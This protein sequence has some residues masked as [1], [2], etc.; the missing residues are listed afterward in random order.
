[1]QPAIGFERAE[2]E[3]LHSAMLASLGVSVAL[4]DS[5]GFI[6]E[7]NE[8]WLRFGLKNG[9]QIPKISPGVNYIEICRDAAKSSVEAA[10]ALDGI[11]GVLRGARPYFVYS[12]PCHSKDEDRWYEM[13]VAPSNLVGGGVIATHERITARG[14]GVYFSEMLDTVRAI[15]WSADL[16]EFR[17]KY[18]SLQQSKSSATLRRCSCRTQVSGSI[19]F[20]A[21]TASG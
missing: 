1:M 14:T 5:N 18:A 11:L 3:R 19:T 4:L 15:L 8:E 2:R 12:Y 6:V 7:V 13:R 17:T 16:P 10:Y 9:A 21:M 20:T